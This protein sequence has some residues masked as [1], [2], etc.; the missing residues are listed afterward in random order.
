MKLFK[1]TKG[2]NSF[3]GILLLFCKLGSISISVNKYIMD[4]SYVP[5]TML[6]LK[7]YQVV[8]KMVPVQKRK[9]GKKKKR[10]VGQ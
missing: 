8:W 7:A 9:R 2:A 1:Y 10:N 4:T 6:G 3:R 5:D